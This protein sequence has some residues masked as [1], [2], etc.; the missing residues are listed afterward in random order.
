VAVRDDIM[1]IVG[2]ERGDLPCFSGRGRSPLG[3]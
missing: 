1:F 2:D 3:A